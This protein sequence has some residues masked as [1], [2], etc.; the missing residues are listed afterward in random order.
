MIVNKTILMMYAPLTTDVTTTMSGRP[1]FYISLFTC[2]T[3]DCN[4]RV[5]S[6]TCQPAPAPRP[7]FQCPT[8]GTAPMQCYYV[9]LAGPSR[10]RRRIAVLQGQGVSLPSPP[11]AV[12][13]PAGTICGQYSV[14]CSAGSSAF[15]GAT[16]T[17]AQCPAGQTV[18]YYTDQLRNPGQL[19]LHRAVRHRGARTPARARAPRRSATR[20]RR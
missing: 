4:V 14:P 1:D 10:G 17:A 11:V 8:P 18:T 16:M 2:S 3:N 13:A 15:N 7:P 19:Q 6:S 9:G 12:P 20:R 5:A